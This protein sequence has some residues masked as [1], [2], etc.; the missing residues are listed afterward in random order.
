VVVNSGALAWRGEAEGA[1]FVQLRGEW[2]PGV[3][4][5][6]CQYLTRGETILRTDPGSFRQ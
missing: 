3:L 4:R 1:G 5:A 6:A 2:L